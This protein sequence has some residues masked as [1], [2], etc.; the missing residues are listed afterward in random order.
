MKM[1][2]SM[3]VSCVCLFTLCSLKANSNLHQ[4]L[5][6]GRH[7]SGEKLIMFSRSRGQRS[8]SRRDDDGNIK[9]QLDARQPL[10]GF[11]SKLIQIL[12]V[13]WRR[14]DYVYRSLDQRSR[15]TLLKFRLWSSISDRSCLCICC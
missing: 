5:H 13:L 8:R 4:I 15:L 2:S 3:F 6:T 1:L 12:I 9:C 10:S 14:T 11:E 7:R